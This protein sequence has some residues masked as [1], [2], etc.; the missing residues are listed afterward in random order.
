MLRMTAKIQEYLSM[1]IEW[2][3]VIDPEERA[4]LVYSRQHPEGAAATMLHTEN[5][6]IRIRLESAFDLDA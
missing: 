1:G 3:W 4:A 2:V 6:D 5:P